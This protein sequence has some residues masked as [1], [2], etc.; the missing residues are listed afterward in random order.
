MVVSVYENRWALGSCAR[1]RACISFSFVVFFF[2]AAKNNLKLG[3]HCER[4]ARK[5]REVEKCSY[6]L[7]VRD[8][9]VLYGVLYD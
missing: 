2:S 3:E 7:V 9:T 6:I 4:R 1:A 8:S 5:V